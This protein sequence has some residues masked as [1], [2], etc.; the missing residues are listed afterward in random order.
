MIR[1]LQVKPLFSNSTSPVRHSK[2]NYSAGCKCIDHPLSS[3]N[4]GVKR[5]MPRISEVIS[6]KFILA[7]R[8]KQVQWG[9]ASGGRWSQ[10]QQC[11]VCSGTGCRSYTPQLLRSSPEH[12]D[13]AAWAAMPHQRDGEAFQSFQ[14]KPPHICHEQRPINTL[15]TSLLR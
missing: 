7:G 14:E 13:C 6:G 1:R 9:K 8:V 11:L 3:Y 4:P 12:T 5:S 2:L 10:V 15:T